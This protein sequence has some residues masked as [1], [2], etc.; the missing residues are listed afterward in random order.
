M[1]KL[2]FTGVYIIFRI[3]LKIIDCGY[4]LEPPRRGGSNRVPTIYVLSRNMKNHQNVLSETNEYPQCMFLSRN[5]KNNVYPC[6]SQFYYIKWGLRGSKLY[7][8]VFVMLRLTSGFVYLRKYFEG[9]HITFEGRRIL[10]LTSIEY[11]IC[12]VI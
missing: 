5:K 1:V 8:C 9:R 12:F 3:L 7:R 4:L 2:G 6:K 10:M 11:F